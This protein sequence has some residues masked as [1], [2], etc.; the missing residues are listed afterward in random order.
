MKR[1]RSWLGIWRREKDADEDRKYFSGLW[2]QREYSRR[3]ER[4]TETSFLFGLLR[5]RRS[6]A[7]GLQLL[8]PGLP[9]PGWPRERIPNSIHGGR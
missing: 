4:V 8:P 5:Y 6:R 1:E 3:G 7:D 2:A 9:G